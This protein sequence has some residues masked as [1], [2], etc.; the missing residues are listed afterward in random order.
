MLLPPHEL[1]AE[2]GMC[3]PVRS[4]TPGV[5]QAPSSGE[6]KFP[7]PAPVMLGVQGSAHFLLLWISFSQEP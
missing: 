2:R 5:N 1:R 3:I 4:C 6:G 7:I